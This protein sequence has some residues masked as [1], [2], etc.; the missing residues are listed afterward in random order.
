[1]QKFKDLMKKSFI[2]FSLLLTVMLSTVAYA[3]ENGKIQGMP[4]LRLSAKKDCC[5]CRRPPCYCVIDDKYECIHCG[6]YKIE[7]KVCT[8]CE[9]SHRNFYCSEKCQRADFDKHRK[10]CN[11]C[12][13]SEE[14]SSSE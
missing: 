2:K 13:S 12:F 10:V 11:A 14:E 8:G 3:S 7:L 6:A 5:G 4:E 9:R 1:M